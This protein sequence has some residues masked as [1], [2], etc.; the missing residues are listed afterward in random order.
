MTEKMTGSPVTPTPQVYT[1]FKDLTPNQFMRRYN[2]VK[3]S[4]WT[5]MGI[6]TLQRW[7]DEVRRR[8]PEV[9]EQLLEAIGEMHLPH[10]LLLVAKMREA[11]AS[12]PHTSDPSTSETSV[13]LP[14]GQTMTLEQAREKWEHA[15][16]Q[17]L[18]VM[19]LLGMVGKE[20][21][22][23][24]SDYVLIPGTAD[25]LPKASTTSGETSTASETAPDVGL[26]KTTGQPSS[27]A[28]AGA[29]TYV[30]SGYGMVAYQRLPL[31]G[32]RD[33]FLAEGFLYVR[34]DVLKA[35]FGH[36]RAG[37]CC[38]PQ[39]EGAGYHASDCWIANAVR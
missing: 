26:P 38:Q 27:E 10:E 13:T 19:R 37:R 21:S 39:S 6:E 2:T 7:D 35:W 34:N 36:L 20:P 1:P 4:Q 29:A 23:N 22:T 8:G 9:R 5:E 14:D 15:K 16:A 25:S 18:P 31:S 12:P 32:K 28:S 3:Q 33:A 17:L 11:Q 24:Q 30:G